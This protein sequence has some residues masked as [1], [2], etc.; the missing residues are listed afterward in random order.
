MGDWGCDSKQRPRFWQCVRVGL[1]HGG[2]R[3]WNRCIQDD[4]KFLMNSVK[5][6]MPEEDTIVTPLLRRAADNWR[7]LVPWAGGGL[8]AIASSLISVSVTMG[9]RQ[10]D[11]E[12]LAKS[13]SDLTIEVK[14]MR[15]EVRQVSDAQIE[16]KGDLKTVSGNI[17]DFEDWRNRVTGV[18]ETLS[19]P[20]L[21]NHHTR[22]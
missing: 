10:A 14:E 11:Q 3:R 9:H 2:Q 20:K 16:M 18:A 22:K 6:V 13:V 12:M 21:R 8:I 7:S 15:G 1:H 4:F 5:L 17:N 19:I